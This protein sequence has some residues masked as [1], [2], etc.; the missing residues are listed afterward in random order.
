MIHL[1]LYKY[2]G[3]IYLFIYFKVESWG[4]VELIL[5]YFSIVMI[6]YTTQKK[7]K[8]KKKRI[9]DAKVG[10]IQY[11]YIYIYAL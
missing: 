7:R 11:I 8:E 1:H 2:Q 4:Q 3:F 9:H 5:Y 6:R 10:R